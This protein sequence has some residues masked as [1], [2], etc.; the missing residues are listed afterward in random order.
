MRGETVKFLWLSSQFTI[1]CFIVHV[2]CY[3]A[4][5]QSPCIVQ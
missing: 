4:N 3:S 2:S 5:L 1:T